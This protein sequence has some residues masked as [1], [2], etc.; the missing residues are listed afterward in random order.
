MTTPYIGMTLP[1]VGSTLGPTWASELNTALESLDSHNHAPGSGALIPTSALNINAALSFADNAATS[2]GYVGLSNLDAVITTGSTD[3]FAYGGDLYYRDGNG[4]NIAITAAGAIST[5]GSGSISGL[6]GTAFGQYLSGV[7]AIYKDTSKPA[8]QLTSQL[9]IYEYDNASANPV[10]LKSPASLASS[11]TW[12]FPTAAAANAV[13]LLTVSSAGVMDTA[14]LAGTSSQITVTQSL[15]SVVL[16]LPA[17]VSTT[18]LTATAAV[19]GATVTASTAIRGPSGSVSVP[20]LSFS[21]DTDTGLYRSASGDVAF[22]SN[23]TAVAGFTSQGL[24]ATSGT[25]SAPGLF[26]IGDTNTGIYSDTAD[27]FTITAG[28]SDSVTFR[29][30]GLL[31]PVGSAAIPSISF[32]SDADTGIYHVSANKV[33]VASNGVEAAHFTDTEAVFAGTLETD[34]GGP[35]KVTIVT[36]T[37]SGGGAVT[38]YSGAAVY[39]AYGR[40]TNNGGSVYTNMIAYADSTSGSMG[41]LG[42]D[43]STQV[44]IQRAGSSTGNTYRVVVF[45]A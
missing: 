32:G 37:D 23:G 25:V 7:F 41:F 14:L 13:E 30:R 20:A 40:T 44:R 31:A 11:Y 29:S 24:Y 16:S 12:T 43:S 33:G 21:T 35:F 22:S 8:K 6:T 17:S 5:A 42:G 36:G 27:S 3:L 9:S 4:I 1:V 34:S 26:F 19:I 45:H 15:S 28:G 10:I 18:N 2:V 38:V 39:G